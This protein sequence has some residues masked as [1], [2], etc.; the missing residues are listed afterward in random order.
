MV[1]GDKPADSLLKFALD[2]VLFEDLLAKSLLYKNED[3]GADVQ[4]H[5]SFSKSVSDKKVSIVPVAGL[6]MEV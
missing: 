2:P 4:W 6:I 3:W 5:K 1:C